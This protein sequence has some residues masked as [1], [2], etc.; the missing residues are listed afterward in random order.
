MKLKSQWKNSLNLIISLVFVA[1]STMPPDVPVV[2]K[3]GP[4]LCY[5]VYTISDKKGE[6]DDEHPLIIEGV[7]YSCYDLILEGLIFP[8]YSYKELKKYIQKSCKETKKCGAVGDWD[9]RTDIIIK[10]AEKYE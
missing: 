9:D 7:P 4:N 6:I 5:Y 8:V 3:I 10:K 2:T 1:C